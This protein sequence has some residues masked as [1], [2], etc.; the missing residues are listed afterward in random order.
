MSRTRRPTR[1]ARRTFAVA[2]FTLLLLLACAAA[3]IVYLRWRERP[4]PTVAGF[5][6]RVST[7]AGD[8]A[9]GV[10]DDANASRARFADPFGV[11]VDAQGNVFVSDGG[12]SNRI[13]MVTPQGAVS[14]VAGGE[15]NFDDGAGASAAFNTPS[16]LALDADGNLYVAD[17]GNNRIRKVARDGAVTTVAGDGAAGFRDGRAAEA[18]FDAPVGV[19]VDKSGNVFVADTYNDRIR[20]VSTQGDV[21]T[22]A[23]GNAPGYADGDASSARLDTPTGIA[24]AANGDLFVADTGNNRLR[25]IAPTGQVSTLNLRAPDGTPV[26]LFTLVGLAVTHDGFLYVTEQNRGR[27][28]QIA[29]DATARLVA[30]AGAGFADGAGQT[31]S[32]FDQPAGVAVDRAGSLYV[33]DAANYLV[34]KI[35]NSGEQNGGANDGAGSP[36]DQMLPRLDAATLGIASLPY[37][38]DPQRGR[39]EVIATIGEVRGGS[40][41][42]EQRDHLHAGIDI[43]AANGATVRAVFDEKVAGVVSSWNFG[44]RNEGLRVGVFTYYH[45]RVGR[46]VNDK[47]FDDPRFKFD[48]DDQGKPARVRVRRGARFREGDA[49]GTVNTM[50]HVHLNFGPPNDEINPLALPLVN[51]S[52]SRAPQIEPGGIQL[53]DAGGNELKEKRGGRLVVRGAV[54]VVV[55]AYDQVDGNA[56]R[57]RLGLYKLGFQVLRA[58]GAPAPGF[59]EPRTQIEFD[60]L[61]SERDAVKIA[62]ADKS[63]ITVYGNEETTFLY[64]L[65]NTLM[66]GRAAAHPWDTSELPAGDYTLRVFASDFSGNTAT[67]N[68][69]VLITVER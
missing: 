61:P 32:R 35:V 68:R 11:A 21:K 65:S 58:D 29:P 16:G 50:Y 53:F 40:D 24:V 36:T 27:V 59:E 5:R 13:R 25:K 46:D 69:D 9:P 28:W 7:V 30:G 17:T 18:E 31:T 62:Y 56:A 49:L 44:S 42:A 22:L 37:P 45:L 48:P 63:G 57:R 52:D 51:F 67:A 4:P 33:A 6:A 23:G 12:A 39:H 20:V 14:T 3:L 19:A 26:E 1:R 41:P 15:E 34:R 66:H 2:S 8:G 38:L 55:G 60:R 43:G 47:T 64:E 10:R 54:R